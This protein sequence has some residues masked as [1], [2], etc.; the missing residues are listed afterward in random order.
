MP[1]DREIIPGQSHYAVP[2]EKCGSLV[3]RREL[4]AEVNGKVYHGRCYGS[5]LDD[6]GT[7][8]Q[9]GICST[10]APTVPLKNNHVPALRNLT[11][12][13]CGGCINKHKLTGDILIAS[14]GVN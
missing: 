14:V 7:P 12:W 2:C 3:S 10:M 1:Q 4:S 8:F 9:C 13:T 5:M 6:A 11:V